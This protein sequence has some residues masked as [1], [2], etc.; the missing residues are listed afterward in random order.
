MHLGLNAAMLRD[1]GVERIVAGAARVLGPRLPSAS[2]EVD[3]ALID[4]ILEEG[5]AP[6][7]EG[8]PGDIKGGFILV[9]S[10][11]D[12]CLPVW[13]GGKISL[14]VGSPERLLLALQ[15]GLTF[16]QNEGQ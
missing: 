3:G 10:G 13:V 2:C 8:L 1:G 9:D 15:R 16:N 6:I 11:N 14:M 5:G 12:D 4:T 7:E